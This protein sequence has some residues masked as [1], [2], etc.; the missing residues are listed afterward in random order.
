MNKMFLK[1]LRINDSHEI[2]VFTLGSITKLIKTPSI[3]N[4]PNL[5]INTEKKLT[6]FALDM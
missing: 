2:I 4:E 6:S 1:N 3:R 5:L